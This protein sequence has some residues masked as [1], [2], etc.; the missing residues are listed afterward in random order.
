M[1]FDGAADAGFADEFDEADAF[2]RAD[3]V[4]DGAEA[5]AEPAGEFDRV[6]V[7]SSS[8][9]RM[10][11]RSGWL[12]AFTY[13]GSSMVVIGFMSPPMLVGG[14]QVHGAGEP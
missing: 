3:V 12:I 7:R 4:G 5:G 14:A 8:I 1:V 10:R 13:R 2:E 6:A 9:A 11:T